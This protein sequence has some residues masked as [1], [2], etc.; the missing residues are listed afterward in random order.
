MKL[1]ES[2][3]EILKRSSPAKTGTRF[4]ACVT[5]MLLVALVASLLFAGL[6]RITV[7]TNAYKDAEATSALEIDYYESLTERTHIVEY[8][9]GERVDTDVTVLK[10]LYRAICLSYEV[11]GN[12]QQPD[13]NFDENHNVRINGTHSAETDNVAYFYTRYLKSSSDM[14]IAVE[15]SLFDIY[16][17]SFG[18]DA[19][20]MFTFNEEL[21]E[22]PVLNTQVA[23][24]LFHYLFVDSSDSIG[25]TGA[26][27]YEAYNRSYYNMLEEA[28]ALILQS[29]PYY[30]THYA[31]YKDAFCTQARLVNIALVISVILSCFIVTLIPKYLFKD[32]K[33]VGYKLF[34]LGVVSTDAEECKWYV[35]LVKTALCSLGAIP[36]VFIMY[37]FPPFN[38]GYE[39]MFTPVTPD[40]AFSLA[41]LVLIIG[42]IDGI[43]AAFSL[44]TEKRQTLVNLVFRETV[45]DSRFVDMG[46]G[47]VNQGREY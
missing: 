38:G 19:T 30:S 22:V 31:A 6:F 15:D 35:P 47:S 44:F 12:S 32:Q 39:A 10:N 42:V 41:W 26:T 25:K 21:S 9:E 40:S 7:S 28:E 14:N 8:V 2:N 45:V 11:F 5:D 4:V 24:Y 36:L 16:K 37:M 27:Y 3:R 46:E 29:E 18:Q 20:F 23:Y 33:T 17:R 13:F 43:V 34:G 1:F